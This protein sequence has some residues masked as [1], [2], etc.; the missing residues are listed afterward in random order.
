MK[1]F[2]DK[3]QFIKD[4]QSGRYNYLHHLIAEKINQ[5][6]INQDTLQKID[7]LY[8]TAIQH[9]FGDFVVLN[10]LFLKD[11][12]LEIPSILVEQAHD[13]EKNLNKMFLLGEERLITTL[14]Y[15][16][17]EENF[18]SICK[19]SRIIL[20]YRGPFSRLDKNKQEV[21]VK[22]LASAIGGIIT[23]KEY[24]EKKLLNRLPQKLNF[25]AYKPLFIQV[26]LDRWK[27]FY[28]S[29]EYHQK[30]SAD[31]YFR[32]MIHTSR[33]YLPGPNEL[34]DPTPDELD[35]FI[36]FL[37]SLFTPAFLY[38]E[39]Q[40]E[41]YF[42]ILE[43]LIE[44]NARPVL[45]TALGEGNE[46]R[47]Y[48]Q[49][50]LKARKVV[51]RSL[52][53]ISNLKRIEDFQNF[54][55]KIKPSEPYYQKAL[56]VIGMLRNEKSSIYLNN[57]LSRLNQEKTNIALLGLSRI[58]TENNAAR[59]LKKAKKL[60][61]SPR[62]VEKNRAFAQQYLI[63][64]FKIIALSQFPSN[65]RMSFFYKGWELCTHFDTRDKFEIILLVFQ[66]F[67]ELLPAQDKKNIL[68]EL[69]QGLD[70]Q[71]RQAV[72]FEQAKT[73]IKSTEKILNNNRK[74]IIDLLTRNTGDIIISP[75][76][77]LLLLLD[78]ISRNPEDELLPFCEKV[79]Q[80]SRIYYS[81][82]LSQYQK[83]YYFHP[84]TGKKV[85][86]TFRI[87]LQYLCEAV[88]AI[89]GEDCHLFREIIGSLKRS[90][91]TTTDTD[92]EQE[93]ELSPTKQV[94]I[95]QAMSELEKKHQAFIERRKKRLTKS[96]RKA[97][98]E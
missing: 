53:R 57:I 28:Q 50:G 36:H 5:K 21:Q 63:A 48:Y 15:A 79:Y 45:S 39:L 12:S 10:H 19:C 9:F 25:S 49:L 14:H 2:P 6:N 84:D 58:P 13:I 95:P 4:L 42:T 86:L 16:I 41:Y 98:D 60:C 35:S 90:Q 96:R 22:K 72:S 68:T 33:H 44:F 75:S 66:Q 34:T 82:K 59:L 89:A 62:K 27:S 94:K 38:R 52:K 97:G 74:E 55:Q 83:P 30:A 67:A 80:S 77:S 85:E 23:E 24:C 46:Q 17:R 29:Q 18:K 54:C 78:F 71:V 31:R 40:E 43:V 70:I 37:S 51:N 73:H 11:K 7:K 91:K 8:S 61:S 76:E 69:L 65:S 87:I 56:E 1:L 64:Y 93:A 92:P 88:E 32:E 47:F 20:N 81:Q 26:C 3:E